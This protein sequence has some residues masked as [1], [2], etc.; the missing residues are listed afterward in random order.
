[1]SS[2]AAGLLGGL[3]GDAPPVTEG[4][5]LSGLDG[6]NFQLDGLMGGLSLEKVA[7]LEPLQHKPTVLLPTLLL[8]LLLRQLPLLCLQ[9][10]LPTEL[11][12]QMEPSP[13]MDPPQLLLPLL[14]VDPSHCLRK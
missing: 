9:P 14:L 3:S 4:T 5:S 11:F 8:P 10:P 1:M 13:L 12:L 6:G 7:L 2:M